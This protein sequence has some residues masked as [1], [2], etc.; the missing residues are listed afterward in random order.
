MTRSLVD[1]LYYKLMLLFSFK[2]TCQPVCVCLSG[3]YCYFE[4]TEL[5]SWYY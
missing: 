2:G 4:Q 3:V 1:I 5:Q